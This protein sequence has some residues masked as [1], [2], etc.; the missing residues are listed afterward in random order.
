MSGD[1]SGQTA[2][3][4]GA[5]SGIGFGVASALAEEGANVAFWSRS[6]E[7]LRAA[8]ESLPD[9]SATRT[10]CHEV[11]VRNRTQVEAAA[12]EA[13]QRL[14]AVDLLVN[15]AGTAGPAGLD[16]QVDPDA[17][18]ECVETSVRGS[19]L[20]ARAVLPVM[21]REGVGRIVDVVS[22]TGTGAF[23]LIGATSVAKTALIRHVENLA[24]ATEGTGVLAFA[25]HPGTVKTKLLESYRSDARMAAFLDS[26]PTEAYAEPRAVGRVVLRIARGELDALSGRFVDATSDLDGAVAALATGPEDVLTL[27]LRSPGTSTA[28]A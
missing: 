3:V 4:T 16:W 23:P 2:V 21:L 1:L 10:L 26:L 22:V 7:R 5:S 19:F 15:A 17:W 27:R 12:E 6:T 11:D 13:F 8:V 25:L 14:G 18:W 20:C 24:A 9:Q 28:E